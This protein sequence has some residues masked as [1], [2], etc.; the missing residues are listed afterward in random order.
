MLILSVQGHYEGTEVNL[1]LVAHLVSEHAASLQSENKKR[2]EIVQRNNTAI[3]EENSAL[4]DK[5][6]LYS[7]C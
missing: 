4:L 5:G 7:Q 6:D 2:S 3:Q 1:G